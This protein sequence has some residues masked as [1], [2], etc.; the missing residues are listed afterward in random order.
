MI[1]ECVCYD[2]DSIIWLWL[3]MFFNFPSA[4][5]YFFARKLPNFNLEISFLLKRIKF[6]NKPEAHL[7]FAEIYME[8]NIVKQAK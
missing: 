7:L 6:C 8:Q 2:P 3:L 4:I 1:W 5:I